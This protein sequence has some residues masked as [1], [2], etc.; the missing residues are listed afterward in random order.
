MVHISKD[1]VLFEVQMVMTLTH[2][3]FTL[4]ILLKFYFSIQGYDALVI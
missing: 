2:H 4:L 1:F 3:I